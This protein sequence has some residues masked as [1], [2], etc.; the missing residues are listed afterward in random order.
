[1][2]QK[3]SL[4]TVSARYKTSDYLSSP[5][6]ARSKL[7]TAIVALSGIAATAITPVNAATLTLKPKVDESGRL[8]RRIQEPEQ[9]E[10][11]I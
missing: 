2:K 3:L 5:P 6:S 9:A 1:M 7:A 4:R 8:V 10:R 11:S